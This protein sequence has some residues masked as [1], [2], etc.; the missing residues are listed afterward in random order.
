MKIKLL[1]LI[2]TLAF[3]L[4]TNIT[5]ANHL[6]DHLLFSAKMDGGQLDPAIDTDA[7]GVSSFTL[8][9][10]RDQLCVNV[11]VNGLSGAITAAHIHAG[12]LGESGDVLVNLSS[13]IIGNQINITIT[14]ADLTSEVIA[15]LITGNS[16]INIHTA[17]NEGGEIR[18]QITMETD[19]SFVVSADGTGFDPEVVTEAQGL[20]VFNLSKD[21]SLIT[22]NFVADG[23][24]GPITAS[25]LHLGAPGEA[26]AVLQNLSAD[27]S[28]NIISGSFAPSPELLMNMMTGNVYINVHTVANPAGEI[29]G[30]LWKKDFGFDSWINSAQ[31]VTS[32]DSEGYGVSSFSINATLD[33]IWYDVLLGNLSGPITAAHLHQAIVGE[34]GDVVIN[35]ADDIVGNR[36][37][38]WIAGAE[39]TDEVINLLLRG[40]TYLNIHTD[41]YPAGEVRGQV[42]RLAREGYTALLT[43]GQQSPIVVTD[44]Y[45][46]GIVSIDRDL[47]NAHFMFVIGDLPGDLTAAHFHTAAAG[48]SG[49]VI[50]NLSPYFAGAANDAAFGY[51][52]NDDAMPFEIGS[53]LLFEDDL[54]Y[55]NVHTDENPSGEIR[56][57]I[58]RGVNCYNLLS[59]E[60]N[61]TEKELEVYPNPFNELLTINTSDINGELT[62]EIINLSGQIVYSKNNVTGGANMQIETN[63]IEKGIYFVVIKNTANQIAIQKVTKL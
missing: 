1:S 4:V 18:G 12:A 19:W 34:I 27:I 7:L 58:N 60:Q 40:E 24:S 11:A 59:V 55:I 8:N 22:Y 26:G 35:F 32:S 49:D 53:S 17:E 45:G 21:Q 37:T 5:N 42:Y 33:T 52:K 28:G 31:A 62:I 56:G 23:L 48:E 54:V 29:R 47:T 10:S 51:W 20:G 46:A 38:G 25:H 61:E 30:Q 9:N 16:Y 13:G 36:I 14:G 50:Y 63:Q 57:Q 41:S 43:G 3:A 39:V 2:C 6:G 44:G 15:A